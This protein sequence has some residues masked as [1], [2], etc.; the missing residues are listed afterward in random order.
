MNNATNSSE[1]I[2]SSISGSGG[3]IYYDCDEKRLDCKVGINHT[4]FTLNYAVV[5]GGAL[6]WDDVEP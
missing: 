3:A 5:K 1:A 6:H 2:Y 4:N